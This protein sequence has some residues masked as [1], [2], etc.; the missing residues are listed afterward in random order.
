MAAK[1]FYL[2]ATTGNSWRTIDEAT[3][4]AATNADGWVVSTGSTNHSEYAVGVER[5]AS[6]FTG[7]TVPDGSLDTS[8]KDA[9]RSTNAYTGDF[10]SAN[11]VFNFVVRN[12]W[13][14]T[15]RTRATCSRT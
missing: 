15:P 12:R 6:T 1:N 11:W 14:S 7:T 10:A 13:G 3:Q 8:L 9:F 2:T 5:A 4:A